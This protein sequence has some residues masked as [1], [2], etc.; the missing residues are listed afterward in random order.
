MAQ[1]KEP[2]DR[3]QG[4]RDHLP[5]CSSSSTVAAAAW[6][7]LLM[8]AAFAT[9]YLVANNSVLVSKG[10]FLLVSAR[11]NSSALAHDQQVTASTM[12][13]QQ[14]GNNSVAG[15][16]QNL[17]Q[18]GAAG[19]PVYHMERY[20]SPVAHGPR[21]KKVLNNVT[22]PSWEQ[23]HLIQPN[24]AKGDWSSLAMGHWYSTRAG[25]LLFEPDACQLRRLTAD[26]ARQCLAN[27][28]LTFVGDSV[29]RY[30]YLSMAHF[31]AR[32]KYIQRYADDGAPSLVIERMWPN[33]TVFYNTGSRMLQHKDASASATEH[34]D[35]HRLNLDTTTREDR[36][37]TVNVSE[38]A[39]RPAHAVV[40]VAYKQAF[41]MKTNVVQE[42]LDAVRRTVNASESA[43]KILVANLGFWMGTKMPPAHTYAAVAA[44]YEPMF[45][46]IAMLPKNNSGV[47]YI[48]KSTTAM[49]T[50]SAPRSPW[51]L[52]Y[53]DLLIDLAYQ[54]GWNVADA[55]GVTHSLN[56][57][58]LRGLWD[59]VHFMPFVYDQLNNVLLNGLC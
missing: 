54:Q 5:G 59:N 47:Q 46:D 30:Q 27:R 4:W 20:L 14:H 21:Y 2:L 44:L 31:L 3:I 1:T 8:L 11:R 13:E 45:K 17:S 49:A 18:A 22:L 34:C 32:G 35:C 23:R 55:F 29:S 39:G 40:R 26:A 43:S 57:A 33:F 12:T 41:G 42:T 15:Q 38:L 50:E 36:T 9:T 25:E 58:K 53:H 10:T 56:V 37:L 7:M 19:A 51:A 48:W 16:A 6:G 28:T 52:S 24:C